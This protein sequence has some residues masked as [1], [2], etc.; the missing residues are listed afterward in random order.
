MVHLGTKPF[1]KEMKTQAN[2][3]FLKLIATSTHLSN[4]A[5]RKVTDNNGAQ[6][7]T[8]LQPIWKAALKPLHS[9]LNLHVVNWPGVE[10]TIIQFPPSPCTD[11]V[12]RRTWTTFLNRLCL[13]VEL[14][15]FID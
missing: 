15:H 13:Q 1:P 8:R 4:C 12:T 2:I 14:Y 5:T 9:C 3:T 10:A 11:E 6:L 7:K